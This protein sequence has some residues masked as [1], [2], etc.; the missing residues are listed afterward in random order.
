MIV[1]TEIQKYMIQVIPLYED[2]NLARLPDA[3]TTQGGLQRRLERHHP[4]MLL[5]LSHDLG[6]DATQFVLNLSAMP[7]IC[8]GQG[9]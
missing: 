6:P 9:P 2:L 7:S 8:V 5:E 3:Q 1:S 4:A